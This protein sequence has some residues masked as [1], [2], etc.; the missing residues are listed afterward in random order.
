[1][2]ISNED[3]L[4]SSCERSYWLEKQLLKEFCFDE[5]ES[6]GFQSWIQ[7][8]ELKEKNVYMMYSSTQVSSHGPTLAHGCGSQT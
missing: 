1:M 3:M 7:F 5:K 2:S 6:L 4:E 8:S